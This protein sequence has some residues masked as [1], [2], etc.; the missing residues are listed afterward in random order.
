VDRALLPSP[1]LVLSPLPE[2]RAASA[3]LSPL[4]ARF[5]RLPLQAL[6]PRLQSLYRNRLCGL[7]V[8]SQPSGLT[9]PGCVQ[10]GEQCPVGGR[11]GSKSHDRAQPAA[12]APSQRLHA[13]K[14]STADGP[15]YRDRRD[16]PE[17]G[18]KKASPIATPQIHHGVGPTNAEG[19]APT[20]WIVLRWWA[21]LG[22]AVGGVG[23]G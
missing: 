15:R 4:Q 19:T 22:G 18:G 1:R 8:V 3:R 14:R 20:R 16:V 10:G 17:C 12:A 23:C 13:L 6:P 7:R 2:G 5:A 11:V 9:A 21:P